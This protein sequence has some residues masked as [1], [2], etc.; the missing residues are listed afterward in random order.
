MMHV[1]QIGMCGIALL[2]SAVSLRGAGPDTLLADAA[3]KMDRAKIR[4]LLQQRVD[5]N[6]PQGSNIV[7]YS[8]LRFYL[9]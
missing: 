8:T 7:I 9:P 4:A 5:V 3:E 1:K 6:T 2:L